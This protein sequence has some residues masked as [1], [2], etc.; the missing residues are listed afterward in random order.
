MIETPRLRLR[1]HRAEDHAACAAMW[2]DPAVTR[3]IGGQPSTSTQSWQRLL[4]YVGH[5]SLAGFGYWAIEERSGGA[6]VGELGFADCW[7]ELEPSISGAPEA[8]WALAPRMHGR[9]YATEAL[10]A[11]HAWG[12]ANLA[13][14]RTV[15][16]IA[17]GNEPS[18]RLAARFGYRELA[19]TTYRGEATILYERRR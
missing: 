7:R 19:R 17:P 3:F 13:A 14:E 12:D 4:A 18:L 6:F 16:L 5:W 9:G 11:A 15:C 10:R 8:G 1:P 2:A